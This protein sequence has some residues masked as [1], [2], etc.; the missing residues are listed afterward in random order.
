MK[1]TL[2]TFPKVCVLLTIQ[3]PVLALF[4]KE[5]ARMLNSFK[6]SFEAR[7][8]EKQLSVCFQGF[9]VLLN[10]IN[11]SSTLIKKTTTSTNFSIL[12]HEKLRDWLL[13]AASYK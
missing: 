6:A 4:V 9:T 3:P 8:T 1:S 11:S 5:E 2:V 7:C 10:T 12:F 13:I